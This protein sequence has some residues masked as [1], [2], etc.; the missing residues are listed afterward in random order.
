MAPVWERAEEEEEEEEVEA[1]RCHMASKIKGCVKYSTPTRLRVRAA[2]STR[3]KDMMPNPRQ[4]QAE[5]M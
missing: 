5:T 1:E 3:V 4:T 2:A